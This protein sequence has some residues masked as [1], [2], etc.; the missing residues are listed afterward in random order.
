MKYTVRPTSDVTG[1]GG[2]RQASQFTTTWSDAVTLLERELDM[3]KATDIVLELDVRERDIRM[4]GQVRANTR[5]ASGRA[6]L[7]FDSRH[8]ALVYAT[9]R[10]VRQPG[11]RFR[12]MEDW[13]HNVYAMAKALEALRLVDRY[14][15]TSGQQYTGFKAIGGGSAIA[16]GP[17][18][19]TD[20]EALQVLI[21]IVGEDADWAD[22]AELHRK[23]RAAAH[24]DRRGGD[25]SAWDQVELAGRALGVAR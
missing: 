4:D 16:T 6:R 8:G 25:Q 13:Q 18:P 7:A 1:F 20:D 23:A 5:A 21:A 11:S 14:G 10:F 2:T 12:M 22:D 15:V 24:P 3:L 19:M 17:A 9:D